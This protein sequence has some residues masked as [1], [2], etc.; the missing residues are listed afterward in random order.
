LQVVGEA[1][2]DIKNLENYQ[3][4]AERLHLEAKKRL[5]DLN[6]QV[7]ASEKLLADASEA[8]RQ[9]KARAGEAHKL[10]A[11]TLTNAKAQA[12]RIVAEAKAEFDRQVKLNEQRL[13][14]HTMA[15]EEAMKQLDLKKE[16]LDGE[17]DQ[18]KDALAALDE[19]MAELR[20]KLS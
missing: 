13:A 1:L 6:Q 3:A 8:E 4:E 2:N 7:G 15:T 10:A 16:F 19:R 17:I 14:D 12:E 20:A 18:R 11:T 5:A 9:G